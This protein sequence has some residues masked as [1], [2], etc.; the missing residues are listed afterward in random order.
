MG[1]LLP[2]FCC[3]HW[4][5]VVQAFGGCVLL[6]WCV[7][8]LS[9]YLRP[10]A[11]FAFLQYLRNMPL[12]AFLGGFRGFWGCCVGLCWLGALR[13]FCVREWLGG[14]GACCVCALLFVLLSFRF[15]LFSSCPLFFSFRP[16]FVLLP[17]LASALGL[18][19]CLCCGCWLSF[20]F[21]RLQIQKE[22]AQFRA[23]SLVLL[24]VV[25]MRLLIAR[26]LPA[27]PLQPLRESVRNCSN[28]GG[29]RQN[30]G[31]LMR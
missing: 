28:V 29:S 13:G 30:K 18:W 2:A 27:I 26:G 22:R 6:S 10:F 14:F 11:A 25:V 20:P 12:F 16:A 8:S 19:V 4:V 7:P 31:N 1:A 23:S 24:C 17:C 15:L 5:Q 21:G 3:V 9:P